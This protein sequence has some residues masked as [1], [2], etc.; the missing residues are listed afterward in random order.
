MKGPERDAGTFEEAVNALSLIDHH[1][2]GAFRV[3]LN[4]IA[5]EQSITESDR[6]IAAG[7]PSLSW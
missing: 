7:I 6:A 3:P 2:H 1:V 4:R 5:F